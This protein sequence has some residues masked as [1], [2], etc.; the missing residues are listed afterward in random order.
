MDFSTNTKLRLVELWKDQ[1][2][3]KYK[4]QTFVVSYY[5]D[6]PIAFSILLKK[7]NYLLLL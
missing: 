1:T 2:H 6:F 5:N 3:G 7:S 4:E